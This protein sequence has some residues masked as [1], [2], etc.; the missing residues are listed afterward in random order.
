M[1]LENSA[2]DLLLFDLLNEL[3]YHKDAGQLLLKFQ[4]GSTAIWDANRYNEVE[5]PSPRFT[6]GQLRI[7]AIGGHLTMDTESKIRMKR[8]GEPG[9]D[10]DYARE[11]VNFAGDC[12]FATQRHFVDCFLSGAEFESNGEDYL[13]TLRVVEAIY[14]SAEK[15]APV[16]LP[17]SPEVE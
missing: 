1:R 13:K 11:P 5:S 12:V 10:V 8:L 2:L 4:S 16:R 14:E 3:L 7:D 17:G 6:F 9:H 15:R